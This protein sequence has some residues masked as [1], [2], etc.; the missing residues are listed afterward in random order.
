M[1][2]QNSH[3]NKSALNGKWATCVWIT[4]EIP[5]ISNE[6]IIIERY[7]IKLSLYIDKN[8]NLYHIFL[9]LYPWLNVLRWMAKLTRVTKIIIDLANNTKYP[10]LIYILSYFYQLMHLFIIKYILLSYPK[11]EKKLY[12]FLSSFDHI[13]LEIT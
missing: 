3:T 2:H 5:V 6:L 1:Q 4:W 10:P 9:I 8:I 13:I 11:R 7:N 12:W